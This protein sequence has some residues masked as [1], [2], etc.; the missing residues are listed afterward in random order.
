MFRKPRRKIS[1]RQHMHGQPGGMAACTLR[2]ACMT[3]LN[4]ALSMCFPH[5]STIR[6]W[7]ACLGRIY[8]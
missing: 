3:F 1:L 4:L 7:G 8:A 6:S 2:N 5:R